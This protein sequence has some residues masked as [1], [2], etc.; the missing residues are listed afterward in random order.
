MYDIV[1][2]LHVNVPACGTCIKYYWK[3]LKK[4]VLLMRLLFMVRFSAFIMFITYTFHIRLYI[5]YNVIFTDI[6]N[7]CRQEWANIIW[8]DYRS[9][10]HKCITCQSYV[11]S[12][13]LVCVC[14]IHHCVHLNGLQLFLFLPVW[15][16]C[17]KWWHISMRHN[18]DV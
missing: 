1:Y 4:Y 10:Y 18:I 11:V 7:H 13:E 16:L 8:T 9:I 6:W 5:I 3:F 2:L 12:Y 15:C 17:C 14:I